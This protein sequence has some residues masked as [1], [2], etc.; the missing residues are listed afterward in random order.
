MEDFSN[1]GGGGLG[2]YSNN[3]QM[4]NGMG[5]PMMPGGQQQMMMG[6]GYAQQGPMMGAP[7]MMGGPMMPGPGAPMMGYGAPGMMNPNFGGMTGLDPGQM[8][9][10]Q[11]WGCVS[12]G[13]CVKQKMCAIEAITGC[14]TPN[15]YYV[16]EKAPSGQVKKKK[17]FKCKEK[18]GWCA[19]NCMSADCKPF[20]MEIKK[21]FKDEDYDTGETV[22]QMTRECKC[23]C[24]CCNRPEV[25]VYLTEGGQQL[26]LGKVVDTWDCVNYTY[27]V[28]DESD[29]IKFFIQASCC[30]LGFCCGCPCDAC[31][32]ITF[33]LWTGDKEVPQSPII[34]KGKG[35]LKNT[36]S[37][38]DDFYVDFNQSATW[39][40]KTLL[41]ASILMIDFMQFEEKGGQ[42]NKGGQG[43]DI[44][45]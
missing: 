37:T 17:M 38:A 33:D 18:S 28:Y 13:I 23:T 10:Q 7:G 41:L 26:Y 8:S 3:D 22:I 36:I 4:N 16:Y 19:R 35:C 12:T 27:K 30:Q 2:V 31:E 24:L 6:S 21:C 29:K 20:D 42:R 44:D 9:V 39:Q 34:K 15:R 45:I 25:K 5:A 14:D 11:I 40:D 43:A 32:K 1:R